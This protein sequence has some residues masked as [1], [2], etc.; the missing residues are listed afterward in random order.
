MIP[1][2]STNS[3]DGFED[4]CAKPGA[5]WLL[6]YPDKDPHEQ[7]IWWRAYKP[8][9]AQAFH[10]RCGDLAMFIT[11]GDV[12]HFLAC[13]H[14]GGKT[15]PHR[16]QAFEWANYR[17]ADAATNVRKGTLDDQILDPFEIQSD[18]F[19]IDLFSFQLLPTAK[20][21][22]HLTKKAQTTIDELCLN[23]DFRIRQLRRRYY[24][25]YWLCQTT[26]AFAMLEQD[27]PLIA[28]AVRSR[29][30]QGLPLPNPNQYPTPLPA[31]PL[32]QR[33]YQPRPRKP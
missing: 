18:W 20:L 27:A 32:R 22:S 5:A 33:P 13:G 6:A 14:R 30:A 9:L 31:V 11:D 29:S 1:V 4:N 17:Y 25:R 2:A 10:H 8:H 12:D 15:S 19:E 24:E 21:P 23:T 7:S 16:Q 28:K 26:E 3:P